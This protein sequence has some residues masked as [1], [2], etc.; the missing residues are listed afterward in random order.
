MTTFPFKDS[1][2]VFAWLMGFVNVEKGQKTEF[3]LDRMR[4]LCGSLGHPERSSPVIHVAGSK[5]KGS[6]SMM[7]A[8]ILE[9]AGLRTGLYTSPHLLRWKERMTLAG[10]EMD[11]EP[12]LESVGRL[13]PLVE[14]KLPED[15]V[16]EELPTYFE[17]TTL[18][19]FEA[20]A[21]SRCQAA[22]I[23]T[24]L[25]GRLDS[26]NVVDSAAS[27]IMP[28]ELE[29]T[30]WLGDS[31][32]KIAFEKAGIIKPGKPC[33]L[34]SQKPEARAVFESACAGRGSELIDVAQ[35]ATIRS[36]ALDRK[37]TTASIALPGCGALE[38]EGLYRVPLVGSVQAE[39]MAIAML[40]ARVL[41]P[42]LDPETARKGLNRASL[43]ARFQVLDLEPPVVLDGAHTPA[44]IR[45]CVESF[46]R[47]FPGDADLV[48]A[49]AYDK[50]HEE[51]AAMLKGKFRKVTITRPGTFKQSE[52]LCVAESFGLARGECVLVEDTKE[53]LSLAREDAATGG[54]ALLVTG[55]FYLCA[56]AIAFFG[57]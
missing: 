31:I 38:N 33:V 5:G 25:G 48:F 8:R 19:A 46:S 35:H 24:G 28:I 45:L 14:G 13:F 29:H 54:R 22:V 2:A 49:C 57:E 9:A 37:G 7:I 52:P 36:V 27:V 40:A 42:G 16:G 1:D 44:S 50:K 39:N 18:V 23:E 10:E 11:E 12:I 20:F 41:L 53:A 34:S 32:E 47:L 51:M 15:F 17:L 21:L 3:K 30:E 55:S 26:T 43:P 56:E 4:S 6:V